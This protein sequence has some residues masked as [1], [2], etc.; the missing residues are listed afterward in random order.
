M[1]SSS[2]RKRDNPHAQGLTVD[3]CQLV[4]LR[5]WFVDLYRGLAGVLQLGGASCPDESEA[6]TQYRRSSLQR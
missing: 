6:Q 2:D 5:R 4:L 3:V 1:S